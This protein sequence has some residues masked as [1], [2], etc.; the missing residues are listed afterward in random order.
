MLKKN[1]FV[2][3]IILSSLIV[4]FSSMVY[5]M[6]LD[7]MPNELSRVVRYNF[8]ISTSDAHNYVEIAQNIINYRTFSSSPKPPLILNS[9]RA[10]GYPAFVAFLVVIFGSYL[11]VSITQIILV[12]LTAILILKMGEKLFSR[13]AG[14]MAAIFYILDPTTIFHSLVILSDIPFVFLLVLIIYLLFFIRP[15]S[16]GIVILS[17]FLLGL[18]VLFRPIGSFL[19]ILLMGFY[20]LIN[21]KK[22]ELKKIITYVCLFMAAFVITIMPWLI[23][24]KIEFGVFAIS[25]VGD[26]NL[27]NLNLPEY[28]SSII[29]AKTMEDIRRELYKEYKLENISNDE[30]FSLKNV[31][32]FRS[33]FWSYFSQN[34][35]GYI[36][37]HL[38][39]TV[40]FF[41][42][43]G[44]KTV[45]GIIPA[46]KSSD[47]PKQPVATQRAMQLNLLVHGKF[48]ALLRELKN[49]ILFSLESM[50]WLLLTLT[51]L[52]S[53]IFIKENKFLIALFLIL[54]F[55]FAILTGPVSYSRYRLP[56][57]PFMLLLAFVSF[58]KVTYLF[59]QK[60]QIIKNKIALD[61]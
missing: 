51:A 48:S 23:R 43:S 50:I 36:K 6:K 19:P 41:L 38:I 30:L 18:A 11:A 9:F 8:L 16:S 33:V 10:P 1:I 32:L 54:I 39:K 49:N 15:N 26:S 4:Y 40:P 25:S 35:L 5:L 57:E 27:F 55:Y 29:P 14:F 44:I 46:L 24:N 17:G 47:L 59:K 52:V 42:N 53:I 34:P 28:L 61:S 12:I 7:Y 58:T 13:T 37:F 45:Y 60:F 31:Q 21:A 2:I 22:L 20:T 56:A 3:I